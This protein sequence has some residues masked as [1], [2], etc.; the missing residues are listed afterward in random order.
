MPDN[1]V[2]IR[3]GRKLAVGA[4]WW[5]IRDDGVP[6]TYIDMLTE[7]RNH[8]SVVYLSLGQA[9]IDAN[10]E[11]IVQVAARHRIDLGTAQTL[12]RLLGEM[13]NEMTKPVDKSQAN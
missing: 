13:I 3:S 7:L 5:E 10:N 4:D 2:V 11:P 12:H 6:V 9:I 1:E 8:N